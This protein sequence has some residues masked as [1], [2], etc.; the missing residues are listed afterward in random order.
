MLRPEAT[1]GARARCH[2]GS[3]RAGIQVASGSPRMLLVE[4]TG[5]TSVVTRSQHGSRSSLL[6]SVHLRA[7]TASRVAWPARARSRRAVAPSPRDVCRVITLLA[8]V[9]GRCRRSLIAGTDCS[10]HSDLMR[11]SMSAIA[12]PDDRRSSTGGGAAEHSTHA[13]AQHTGQDTTAKDTPGTAEAQ[14]VMGLGQR[15]QY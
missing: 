1:L 2:S 11:G 7:V 9:P 14:V 5:Q 6:M 13:E 12:R 15:L 10:A 8:R 3:S 4:S